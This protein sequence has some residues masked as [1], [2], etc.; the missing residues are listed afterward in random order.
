MKKLL[1]L[2]TDALLDLWVRIVGTPIKERQS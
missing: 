2:L 1:T